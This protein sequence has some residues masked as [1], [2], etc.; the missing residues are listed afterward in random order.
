MV[1]GISSHDLASLLPLILHTPERPSYLNP[2]LTFFGHSR[3]HLSISKYDQEHP[4]Q[5]SF[6]V[7]RNTLHSCLADRAYLSRTRSLTF[8]QVSF[9]VA[10]NTLY[11]SRANRAY[12][13]CPSACLATH[14]CR[15]LAQRWQLGVSRFS[16][17]TFC[18]I[19]LGRSVKLVFTVRGPVYF[20]GLS[21]FPHLSRMRVLPASRTRPR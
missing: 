19:R 7:T 15:S 21:S 5:V 20:S 9:Y 1:F 13:A 14:P 11:S 12:E 16:Y 8:S 18:F 2:I 6:H 17:S 3:A 10:R 4:S